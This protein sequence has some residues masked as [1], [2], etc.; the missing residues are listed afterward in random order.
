MKKSL[1]VLAAMII[2]LSANANEKEINSE[3]REVSN[4]LLRQQD[5]KILVDYMEI[6]DALVNDNFEQAKK[7]ASKMDEGLAGV[8]L[9]R[10]QRESLESAIEN[11]A[12]AEDIATQRR[13]FAQLS[14]H[15]YHLVRKSDF[16]DQTLYLQTCG[17][18]MGGQGA[19]W[20]SYDEEV[21][22]PYM[23]QKMPGCGSVEEKTVR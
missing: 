6:K 4:P 1:M 10:A 13:Y 3:H 9:N 18:A 14:Q 16:T 19:D 17:M 20:I 2:T 7:V 8:D 23:G 22:N 11:L 15:L 5:R 12:T 21:R